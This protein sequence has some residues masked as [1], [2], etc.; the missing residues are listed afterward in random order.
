MRFYNKVLAL[1]SS[2]MFE[3]LGVEKDELDSIK[4]MFVWEHDTHS[5]TGII[6]RKDIKS[7]EYL[8][9][10][11]QTSFWKRRG[12]YPNFATIYRIPIDGSSY[13][14]DIR[15]SDLNPTVTKH[16]PGKSVEYDAVMSQRVFDFMENLLYSAH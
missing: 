2:D 8:E 7:T 9:S 11:W 15:E 1:V 5:E 12:I 6:S 3:Q 10:A 16:Q 14:I 13:E 4:V